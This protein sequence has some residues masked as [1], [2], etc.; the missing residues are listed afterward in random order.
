[1]FLGRYGDSLN[2]WADI[3]T[4]A[5]AWCVSKQEAKMAI[6]VPT[7]VNGRDRIE[8]NAG[9]VYGPILYP[10]MVTN[11]K[12]IWPLEGEAS[13]AKSIKQ[14]FPFQIKRET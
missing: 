6:G 12:F 5:Q 1:M 8:F 9:R 7:Y 14:F 4:I 11:W 2:P 3:I 10:Y 13:P